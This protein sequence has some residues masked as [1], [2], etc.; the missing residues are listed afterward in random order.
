MLIDSLFERVRTRNLLFMAVA[1]LLA[2]LLSIRY[3]I[4]PRFDPSLSQG[5]V[6]LISQIIDNV[7]TTIVVTVL[8]TAIL[9]WIAPPRARRAG[10]YLV[11]PREL[12]GHFHDGLATSAT[13]RFFGGCGRHFRSAV[14]NTMKQ[15]AQ[16][17]STSKSVTAIVLNPENEIL[18]ERHARYRAGTRRGQMEGNW[19]SARVK[20]EL[21]ATIVTT[22]ATSFNQGLLDVEI[23]LSDY[24]SSFRVDISQSFAI[25]TREDPTAPALRSEEGSYYYN[26]QMD[27][28]RLLKEQSTLV[29]SGAPQCANVSDVQSLRRALTAMDLSSCQLSDPELTEVVRIVRNPE[30]PYQP[31]AV[32]RSEST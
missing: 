14:L 21:I 27:E 20:Q 15:R 19:T 23:L 30:N 22:K 9:W 24:F 16:A 2:V 4:L 25:Q 32:D 13:W 6:P 18:C 31:V 10:V 7:S 12:P 1:G 11:E 28:F 26:A 17:E 5:L 8:V 3:C 29:R